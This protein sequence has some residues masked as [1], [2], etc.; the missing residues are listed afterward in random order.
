MEVDSVVLDVIG[1]IANAGNQA[2]GARALHHAARELLAERFAGLAADGP[3]Q[4]VAITAGPPLSV[5]VA[6]QARSVGP[7]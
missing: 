3:R 2:A 4:A 6:R 7:G 1:D 5:R